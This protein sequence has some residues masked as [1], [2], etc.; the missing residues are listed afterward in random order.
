MS[1]MRDQKVYV[2]G[3]DL[4]GH[5]NALSIQHS[6]EEV[7]DTRLNE[8]TRRTVAGLRSTQ[9]EM[10]GYTPRSEHRWVTPGEI[11]RSFMRR[12]FEPADEALFAGSGEVGQ[13]AIAMRAHKMEYRQGG[14][15]GDQDSFDLTLAG[16]GPVSRRILF[17]SGAPGTGDWIGAGHLPANVVMRGVIHVGGDVSGR[18][19]DVVYTSG[20]NAGRAVALS[21]NIEAIAYVG[22]VISVIYNT[23]T[24]RL[25]GHFSL[26]TGRITNRLSGGS[27]TPTLNDLN[28]A[29]GEWLSMTGIGSGAYV[30]ATKNTDDDSLNHLY[31]IEYGARGGSTGT[32]RQIGSATRWGIEELHSGPLA[33]DGTQLLM[34]GGS[35]GLEVVTHSDG[36]AAVIGRGYGRESDGSLSNPLYPE[37]LRRRLWDMKWDPR[38]SRLIGLASDGLYEIDTGDGGGRRIT[39]DEW[40]SLTG[41]DEARALLIIPSGSDA[42]L[43]VVGE[44]RQTLT[45][46]VD[47]P[48]SV[49]IE[50]DTSPTES[51]PTKR[52][53][54]DLYAPVAMEFEIDGGSGG[55]RESYW[56]V[57][58]SVDAS[59]SHAT[60][61]VALEVS[62]MS[63]LQGRPSPPEFVTAPSAGEI[64]VIR[65]D[66]PTVAGLDTQ[67][68]PRITDLRFRYRKVGA[69]T[70]WID[71]AASWSYTEGRQQYFTTTGLVTADEYEWQRSVQDVAGW[72]DWSDSATTFP[73]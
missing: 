20:A 14:A 66:A 72:S 34:Y 73:G 25:F 36:T 10:S 41:E 40:V 70:T 43:Y 47:V 16:S 49:S 50:T 38:T 9:V 65:G 2:A 37:D 61:A 29:L 33:W 17:Y 32:A 59:F 71:R 21:H 8:D 58:A 12:D 4:S 62:E 19:T 7:D 69:A 48:V 57:S 56:R 35:H 11:E 46:V 18:G 42:G 6:R 54:R 68:L 53:E 28:V 45:R 55:I 5:A 15:V 60:L 51:S 3:W 27:D 31:Q 44:S 67:A 22:N 30:Y 13:L 24:V 1:I 39:S 26:A 23:G 63:A 52:W 64:R